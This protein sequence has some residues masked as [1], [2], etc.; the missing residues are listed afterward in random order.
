MKTPSK[1]GSLVSCPGIPEFHAH[2]IKAAS[3]RDS[4]DAIYPVKNKRNI[5]LRPGNAPAVRWTGSDMACAGKIRI[6]LHQWR[7]VI[8]HYNEL[9]F[10]RTPAHGR[11]TDSLIVTAAG[12][13]GRMLSRAI[14]LSNPV[15]QSSNIS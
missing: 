5:F 2:D 9:A 12:L 10:S 8:L 11:Y 14:P 3:F 1:P 15:L 13:E 4:G 7:A 6:H